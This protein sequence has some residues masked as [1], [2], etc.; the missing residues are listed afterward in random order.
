MLTNKEK[1]GKVTIK[2][3]FKEIFTVKKSHHLKSFNKI[4]NDSKSHR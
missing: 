4:L 2:K 1:A 3:I